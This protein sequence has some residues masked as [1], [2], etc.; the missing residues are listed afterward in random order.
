MP[1]AS[2]PD[3]MDLRRY[4]RIGAVA[5]DVPAER[6]LRSGPPARRSRLVGGPRMTCKPSTGV[7]H[8]ALAGMSLASGARFGPYEILAGD[9]MTLPVAIDPAKGSIRDI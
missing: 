8:N 5:R 9:I 4:F 7:R 1:A 3:Q 6:P 2:T